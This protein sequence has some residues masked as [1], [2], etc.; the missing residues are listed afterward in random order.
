[1]LVGDSDHVR[2]IEAANKVGQSLEESQRFYDKWGPT[3]EQVSVFL[4]Y[5]FL[6]S[7][8][9]LFLIYS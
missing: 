2:N 8:L 1:M 4:D 7:D 6:F 3:Y 5:I 9:T